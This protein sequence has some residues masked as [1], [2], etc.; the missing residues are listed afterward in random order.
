MVVLDFALS[1]GLIP[2]DEL[3]PFRLKYYSIDS[4]SAH[5]IPR[6][7]QSSNTNRGD[8]LNVALNK[9]SQ[10]PK[11]RVIDLRH[12]SISPD[13][14]F[15]PTSPNAWLKLETLRV[16]FNISTSEGES[17]FDRGSITSMTWPA[18][19]KTFALLKA[20]AKAITQMPMLRRAELRADAL[21]S[22]DE[23]YYFSMG[24]LVSGEEDD[25]LD[26]EVEN[27]AIEEIRQRP[28]LFFCTNSRRGDEDRGAFD[29]IIGIFQT[30]WTVQSPSDL[31]VTFCKPDLL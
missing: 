4:Q 3:R 25:E 8:K 31:F 9:L 17:H 6:V 12:M 26:R 20:F 27:L 10:S 7:A 16:Y 23:F 13:S 2:Q 28:R 1:L 24:F 30:L 19:D 11:L 22:M 18:T 21:D 14:C 15:C 29:E 5:F